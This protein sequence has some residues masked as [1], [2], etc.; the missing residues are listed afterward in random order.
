MH[1]KVE[2]LDTGIIYVEKAG[3]Q[4]ESSLLALYEKIN[5]FVI[6]LRAQDKPVLILSNL[7]KESAMSPKVIKTA[8][9]VGLE[10]DYDKSAT[11][12]SSTYLRNLR[13]LLVRGTQMDQKVANFKTKKEAVTWLLT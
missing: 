13:Q 7:E 4:S 5:E 3:N 12:G 6:G 9:K 8:I 10:L 2:L 1:N 11:F